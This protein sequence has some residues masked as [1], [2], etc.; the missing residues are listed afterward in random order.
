VKG[1]SSRYESGR[2]GWAK[3]KTRASFE[4]IAGGVIG[5][6]DRPEVLIAGRYRD[7]ELVQFGRTTPLTAQSLVLC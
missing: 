6:L 4:V 2:R 7:G 1:A 3:F 5:P